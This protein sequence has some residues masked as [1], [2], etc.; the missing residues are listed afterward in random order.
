MSTLETVALVWCYVTGAI[1]A[2]GVLAVV[3]IWTVEKVLLAK[4]TYE[5]VFTWARH[6]YRNEPL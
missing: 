4:G 1:A 3:S 5:I 2:L 6:H